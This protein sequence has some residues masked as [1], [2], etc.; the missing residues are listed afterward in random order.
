[1]AATAGGQ[2]RREM[3]ESGG[4]APPRRDDG[5]AVVHFDPDGNGPACRMNLVTVK[6]TSVT[7]DVSCQKCLK[8]GAY[9]Y[10]TRRQR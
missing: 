6:K 4:W 7:T 8:S 3:A 1:M 10:A 5:D 2:E 9:K